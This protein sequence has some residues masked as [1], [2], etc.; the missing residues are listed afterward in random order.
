MISVIC[1]A[2]LCA[3]T[4]VY[5]GKNVVAFSMSYTRDMF[6]RGQNKVMVSKLSLLVFYSFNVILNSLNSRLNGSALPDLS[7]KKVKTN[8]L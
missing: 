3:F 4:V 6:G 1:T 2:R 5:R 7:F 8:R